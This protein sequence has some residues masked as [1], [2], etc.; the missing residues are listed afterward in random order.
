MT[1]WEYAWFNVNR[2][3]VV[4]ST[5]GG[6]WEHLSRQLGHAWFQEVFRVLGEDGWELVTM[7]GG[8]NSDTEYLFKRPRPDAPPP[9]P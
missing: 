1:R 7:K 4:F 3:M 8:W 5:S 9:V 6:G 2:E